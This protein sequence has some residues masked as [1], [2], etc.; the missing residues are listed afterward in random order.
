MSNRLKE[1]VIQEAFKE[2]AEHHNNTWVERFFDHPAVTPDVY[3][4]GLILSG[5]DNAQDPIFKWLLAEADRADLQAVQ[6]KEYYEY[7]STEFRAAIEQ[8]LLTANPEGSRHS[9]P[10]KGRGG[11]DSF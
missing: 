9:T 5:N 1:V 4:N 6:S 10:E 7:L 11:Q 3:A 2:G 8:A